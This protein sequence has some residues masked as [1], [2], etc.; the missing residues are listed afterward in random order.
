MLLADDVR[1]KLAAG[2]I[3]GIDRGI[4]AEL[5][6]LARQH[7]RSIQVGEGGGRRGIGQVVGRDIHGLNRGD[8]TGLGGGD[9]LLQDPHFRGQCRLIAHGR[10]HAPEQGRHLDPRQGVTVNVID[11]EQHVTA[12]VAEMLGDGQ[13][14]QP[15]AQTVAGRLVHLAVDQ[16]HLVE[17]ATFLHLVV[18]VITLAGA[19][20][21]AGE[22]RI[23]GMLSRDVADEFHHGHGLAHAGAA[24]QPHL[25][26]LGERTHE[27]DHLDAGL[28]RLG[29]GRLVFEGRCQTMDRHD[30]L[31]ADVALFVD[32][33]T[34]HIH[35]APERF[36]PDRNGNRRAGVGD[37]KATL[38]SV[39]GTHGD[40]PH[41]A[42][43]QLL[44]YFQ[45]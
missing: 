29:T 10:G 43:A 11:K 30:F 27:V 36:G 22:H 9:A 3:Q 12:L 45:R 44:L 37:G 14:R 31:R 38:E 1:I 34:Q 7:H 42:V 13:P 41:H 17:H 39:T 33:P 26:A 24:E 6:H 25:A 8:G 4:N 15:H 2:G 40:G 16:R 32:R 19:L 23:A 35:D 18:E 28:E 21:D 20:A 5:G